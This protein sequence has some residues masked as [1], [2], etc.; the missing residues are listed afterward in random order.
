VLWYYCENCVSLAMG[1]N[2]RTDQKRVAI[3]GIAG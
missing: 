3:P 1:N 2:F